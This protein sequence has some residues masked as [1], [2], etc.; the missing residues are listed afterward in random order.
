V[1]KFLSHKKKGMG[2]YPSRLS[3]A[4]IYF[5]VTSVVCEV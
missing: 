5:R 3:K 1:A 2:F 4:T